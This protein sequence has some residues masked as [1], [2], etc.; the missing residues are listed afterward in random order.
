MT[1]GHAENVALSDLQAPGPHGNK[2]SALPRRRLPDSMPNR[3]WQSAHEMVS[4]RRHCPDQV[5]GVAEFL[6][7]ASQPQPRGCIFGSLFH[8][9]DQTSFNHGANETGRVEGHIVSGQQGRDG[10]PE[11]AL[12]TPLIPAGTQELRQPPRLSAGGTSA[13]PPAGGAKTDGESGHNHNPGA[14]T[15]AEAPVC[16]SDRLDQN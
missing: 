11:G 3:A 7:S 13:T 14:T 4:L 1:A 2:S 8:R 9:M 5:L 10:P 16:G 15:P 6:L 12:T